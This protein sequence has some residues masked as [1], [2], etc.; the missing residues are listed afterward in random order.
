MKTTQI[1]NFKINLTL[2]YDLLTNSIK[3]I[4]LQSGASM[5]MISDWVG[6]LKALY[7][8]QGQLIKRDDQL[9]QYL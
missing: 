3:A 9:L 2:N 4:E 6:S 7:K 5:A 8:T 1:Q